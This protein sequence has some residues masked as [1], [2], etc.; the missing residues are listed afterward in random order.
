[1]M[2]SLLFSL[3]GTIVL[4]AFIVVICSFKRKSNNSSANN[5]HG[6]ALKREN[7]ELRNDSKK[8]KFDDLS[9]D[10]SDSGSDNFVIEEETAED[11]VLRSSPDKNLKSQPHDDT[12]APFRSRKV[13]ILRNDSDGPTDTEVD[14][15]VDERVIYLGGDSDDD[16]ESESD[17]PI[18]TIITGVSS[19]TPP[20][21]GDTSA[22]HLN[23]FESVDETYTPLN[24]MTKK[25]KSSAPLDSGT[26]IHDSRDI[27]EASSTT[28]TPS[29]PFLSP[30]PLPK[31]GYSLQNLETLLSKPSKKS[32]AESAENEEFNLAKHMLDLSQRH[33]SQSL[34]NR[35]T[36]DDEDDFVDLASLGINSKNLFRGIMLSD[37]AFEQT[38]QD[39][40]KKVEEEDDK[41]AEETN[42]IVAKTRERD[43]PLRRSISYTQAIDI[44]EEEVEC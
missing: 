44:E 25:R 8:F 7:F 19:E 28:T 11:E 21:K 29:K 36:E 43:N 37:V 24:P 6:T 40:K 33:R 26:R 34:D 38:D 39:E 12:P 35:T 23:R 27:K 5:I 32:S 9:E 1:M 20:E 30:P 10:E 2:L 3:I 31:R 13:L 42:F 41:A 16:R 14:S 15:F 17:T 18:N 22:A 4:S